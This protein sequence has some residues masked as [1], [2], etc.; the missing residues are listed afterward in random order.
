ME[1]QDDRYVSP[2]DGFRSFSDPIIQRP[3]IPKSMITKEK[4]KMKKNAS[5]IARLLII[6]VMTAILISALGITA[7]AVRDEEITRYV[8]V[9]YPLPEI[10]EKNDFGPPGNWILFS[11]P[12]W[13]WSTET[14]PRRI[15]SHTPAAVP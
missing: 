8:D 7:S 15:S 9:E 4:C 6:A 12:Q 3:E 10:T 2:T 13:Y 11:T 1:L 14:P 5:K